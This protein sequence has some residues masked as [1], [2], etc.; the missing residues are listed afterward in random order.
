MANTGPSIGRAAPLPASAARLRSRAL[1]DAP[2]HDHL[3]PPARR[4]SG[5]PAGQRRTPAL[6]CTALRARS[7]LPAPTSSLG[8]RRPLPG[9]AARL[10]SRALRDAP[11]HDHLRP[12]ARRVSGDPAG[13]RRTPALSCTAL[14]A[15][16]RPPAPTN[17]LGQRRPLPGSAARLRSRALHYASAHDHQGLPARRASGDPTGQRRP[18]VYSVPQGCTELLFTL[19]F[20]SEIFHRPARA[21]PANQ[22]GVGD[23]LSADPPSPTLPLSKQVRPYGPRLRQGRLAGLTRCP[24]AA[25]G[26]KGEAEVR[27]RLRSVPQAAPDCCPPSH[28]SRSAPPGEAP[29]QLRN[30]SRSQ[31]L[32]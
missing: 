12:P 2:A 27:R 6:S 31:P 24:T 5:D 1:R 8:Q 15:R 29:A 25:S 18:P 32:L 20:K 28:A 13:Q 7:R 16:S 14:R 3:R 23:R 19:S 30:R 10:R 17:S 11:A 4:V 9:S 26:S 22:R 21:A